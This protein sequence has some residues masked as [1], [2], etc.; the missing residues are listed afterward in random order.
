MTRA[1]TRGSELTHVPDQDK[2]KLR[3]IR[4]QG[5]RDSDHIRFESQGMGSEMKVEAWVRLGLIH[6]VCLEECIACSNQIQSMILLWN[7]SIKLGYNYVA[8]F[9]EEQDA[10]RRRLDEILQALQ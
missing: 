5:R 6:Q 2:H 1:D 7:K 9:R 3:P 4:L 8:G 10:D